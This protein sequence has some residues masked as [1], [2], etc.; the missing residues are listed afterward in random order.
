MEEKNKELKEGT[1][2]KYTIE[3]E[4]KVISYITLTIE[5]I[6]GSV[7]NLYEQLQDVLGSKQIKI[8]KREI[9]KE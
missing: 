1:E 9:I 3:N 8:L 7:P 2:I 5:Q 6:E 4:F